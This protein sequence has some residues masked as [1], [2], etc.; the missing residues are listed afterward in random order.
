[1]PLGADD[2]IGVGVGTGVGVAAGEAVA[3]GAALA[4][5]V[6]AGVG[7]ARPVCLPWLSGRMP[8]PEDAPHAGSAH[9]RAIAN[10]RLQRCNSPYLKV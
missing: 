5:L 7:V 8:P 3:M 9:K 1:M 6:G 4:E 2:A 10:R